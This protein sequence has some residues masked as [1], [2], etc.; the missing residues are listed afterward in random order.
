M[1]AFESGLLKFL[2]AIAPTVGTLFIHN[3]KSVAIFNISD[4]LFSGIVAQVTAQQPQPAPGTP[5]P[6][7][8]TA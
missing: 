7:S 3:A 6:V 4:E 5:V 2:A 1:N 8:P